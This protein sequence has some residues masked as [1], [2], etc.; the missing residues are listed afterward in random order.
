[1]ASQV[2]LIGGNFQD[3]E[4]NLLSFGYLTLVLSQDENVNNS[5]ICAGITITVNLN[6]YGSVIGGQYVW[7][8]DQILPVNSFYTVTGYKADG[9]MSFGPNNQQVIGSGGTF[10]VGTWIPNQVI[11][12]V[13]AVQAPALS[14]NGTP[15]G[16]QRLLD[17][18]AGT[19]IAIV[20]NGVGRVTISVAGIP[21]TIAFQTNETPNGSQVLLDLHAGS[22]INLTDNGVGRVTIDS[23]A[24]SVSAP[25]PIWTA[26]YFVQSTTPGSFGPGGTNNDIYCYPLFLP[27]GTTVRQITQQLQTAFG[28]P[29]TEFFTVAIYSYDGSIKYVDAGATAFDATILT[30]Q[31]ATITPVSLPAGLY[32]FAFGS[33]SSA[34]DYVYGVNILPAV[35]NLNGALQAVKASASLVAGAMPTTLGTFTDPFLTGWPSFFL[36][37]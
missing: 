11:S 18:Q 37:P 36:Q 33:T 2:E 35:W 6:G 34:I 8:N 5:Q 16:N 7:G 31:T 21:P 20:D 25:R 12:W 27:L 19:N 15:N 13:P 29:G 24:S 9:Q 3:S 17:I 14:T 4:G 32:R 23:T 28:S 30:P 1:M 10:D 22:N 26:D